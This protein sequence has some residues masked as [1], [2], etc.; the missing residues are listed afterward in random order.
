[1]FL[2][3]QGMLEKYSRTS[4]ARKLMARLQQNYSNLILSQKEK[5][6]SHADL[7]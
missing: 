4:A 3:I 2:Y 1:M 5:N 6:P 7:G